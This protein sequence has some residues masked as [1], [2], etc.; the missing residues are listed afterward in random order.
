MGIDV[1]TYMQFQITQGVWERPVKDNQS[2]SIRIC[3]DV[4]NR[5]HGS[6]AR[7]L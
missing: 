6:V 2:E 1:T 4:D 7:T 5:A 3:Q